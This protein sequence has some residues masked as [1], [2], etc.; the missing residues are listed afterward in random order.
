MRLGNG[1]GL[2]WLGALGLGAG[3]PAPAQAADKQDF[4]AC[5]G[6]VHPG[7]QADGMRGAAGSTPYSFGPKLGVVDACTRALASP[8]LLAGQTL[9]RAHLLRARA[10]A[11]LEA[12]D[13]TEALKD[14]D[15][16]EAAMGTTASD[17]FLQRSMGVSLTLLRAL[18]HAQSGDMVRAA[19]LARAAAAARPY[20]LQVQQVAAGILQATRV[21]GD[22][23]PSPWVDVG[24]LDPDAGATALVKEAEVGNFAG[25]VALRPTVAVSWPAAPIASMAPML[26]DPDALRTA[27]ATIVSLHTAYARAATG[28]VAGGRRD[29]VEVRTRVAALRAPTAAGVRPA[30]LAPGASLADGLDRYVAARGR[31]IEARIAVAE[32]RPADA[33]AALLAAPM[34]R[35]AST[36]EL[37]GALRA[38]MPAK[39]AGLVPDLAPFGKEADGDRR[40]ALRS[41]APAALIA[42]ETPRAVVDYARARPDIL[43][44]L[45][46]GALSMGTSLLGGIQR[47][48]GFRSTTNPDGTITVEFIGNTPSA[49]LVQEMTLLR[50]AEVARTAGKPAFVVVARKDYARRLVQSQYGR[51]I[52]STPTGFKTELTIRP[53]ES[54]TE[55]QRA[56]GTVQVIDALGPLYYED[57]PK[58]K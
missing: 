35:D 47:T 30:V 29:L 25:V 57:K 36:I 46:G 19:P 40:E 43:G 49:T 48:D 34:P 9:R 7:K 15:L 17:P 39:D 55:P 12:G 27:T 22:K 4:E 38:A 1:I 18:A 3:L 51:E 56:L 44:A 23:S 50:A 21:A 11:R 5:D 45:I 28:D 2:W 31:Q 8:R 52:S 58:A 13:A 6:R 26:R 24:R 33:I 53:V 10:A 32:K 20:S 42:P 16:A 54:G 41:I 37:L 14:V